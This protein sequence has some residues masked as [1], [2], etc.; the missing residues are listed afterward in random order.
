MKKGFT[1][2]ELIGVIIVLAIIAAIAYPTFIVVV[3]NNKEKA[4]TIQ[5]NQI[6]ESSKNWVME[7]M[8]PDLSSTYVKV[9]TLYNLGLLDKTSGDIIFNPVTGESMMDSCVVVSKDEENNSYKYTF[10]EE[11]SYVSLATELKKQYSSTNTVGLLKDTNGYYYK[12]TNTEVSNN[13]VWWAGILWRVMSID[14]SNNI[15]MISSGPLTVMQP[16]SNPWQTESNYNNS[17]INIWLNSTGVDGVLY[18]GLTDENKAQIVDSTFNIGIR[19]NV[20]EITTTQHFGLLDVDQYTKVGGTNS[21]ID[22]KDSFWL[23][24]RTDSSSLCQLGSGGVI[25]STN[26]SYSFGVRTI[27]KISDIIVKSGDSSLGK[28]TNPYKEMYEAINTNNIKIGDYVSVPYDSS[29]KYCNSS[30][31]CLFRVVSID[32]NSIKVTL[33]GLLNSKSSFGDDGGYTSGTTID[34]MI[35]TFVNTIPSIYRYV[36]N[37]KTFAIGN[38]YFSYGLGVN[39]KVVKTPTITQNYGLPVIGELFSAN[40]IDLSTTTTKTFVDNNII[41][42]ASLSNDYWSMNLFNFS[43]AS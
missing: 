6:L 41:E 26:I 36:G 5:K 2:I 19:D 21:Y 40:D 24:N 23:G 9:S 11:C 29:T 14:N 15:T 12:G 35:S 10:E 22:I 28:L 37:D 42:N 1:L 39:Y 31:R 13:W 43:V 17:Y 32:S 30:N 34:T 4:Y 3:K 27:V 38:Y 16:T 8:S 20:N 18:K 7:N 25:N 33:N